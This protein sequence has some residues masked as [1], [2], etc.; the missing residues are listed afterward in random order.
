MH[1]LDMQGQPCPIPVVNAK[2]M[3][4]DPAVLGVLVL[5]DNLVAVQNL[6]KMANGLGYAF[7]YAAQGEKLFE[8]TLQKFAN[9]KQAANA[10]IATS[11][12]SQPQKTSTGSPGATV[13]ITSNT[14]G[15]GAEELGKILIKGFVF[16]LTELEPSPKTVMFLNSG[17]LLTA[18]N[19]NTVD[20]LKLLQEKG[21]EI[22]TCG[23][24]AN[25]YGLANQLA[26]GSITDMMGISTRLAEALHLISI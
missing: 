15:Q 10:L 13:L 12:Q 23:T 1:K 25:F 3:L 18:Q 8:V 14:M 22:L 20:D 21:C 5:V 4:A 24:C 7:S 26:V 11:G 2:K 9:S 19:A 17:A 16:S 6:E